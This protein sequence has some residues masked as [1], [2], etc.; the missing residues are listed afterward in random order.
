MAPEAF[1]LPVASGQRLCLYH[2]PKAIAAKGAVLYLHPFAEEMNKARRM[3]A[4]Q[5]RLLAE[6]GYAVLQIDLHGCGDSSSDFGDATWQSWLQ[7]VQDARTW[8][9]ERCQAPLWLWGLRAGCLLAAQAA[10]LI[11]EP[12]NFLFWQP[13][14][15]GKQFLQQFLRLK[16]ASE[17]LGGDSKGVMETLKQQLASGQPAEIAGY[18]LSPDLARGLEQAEL[19]PPPRPGRMIWLELS[20]R[21]DANV[22]PASTKRL[23]QWQGAGYSICSQVAPGP[24]FWQTTEIEEAATLLAA[25]VAA[26]EDGSA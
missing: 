18:T 6:H 16:V 22:M 17:L 19:L 11:D 2:P 4:L 1:F 25:T 26:M 8:L 20:S 3:A 13:V 15:S 14:I 9:R 21:P 23:E 5:A 10:E 7:D 24:A 12:V